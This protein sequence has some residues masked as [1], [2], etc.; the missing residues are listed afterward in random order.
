ML[1]PALNG[2][3]NLLKALK[4][5]SGDL[6]KNHTRSSVSDQTNPKRGQRL[7]PTFP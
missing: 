2:E 7:T 3:K 5:F 6:R 4:L 1:K